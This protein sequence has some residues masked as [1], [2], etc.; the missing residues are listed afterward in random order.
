MFP[1]YRDAYKLYRANYDDEKLY[2]TKTLFKDNC[3]VFQMASELR[4]LEKGEYDKLCDDDLLDFMKEGDNELNP[5]A[6]IVSNTYSLAAKCGKEIRA[7]KIM[8]DAYNQ[9]IELLTNRYLKDK[10]KVNRTK[11]SVFKTSQKYFEECLES[12]EKLN[13]LAL[14]R[15]THVIKMIEEDR[16]TLD[17]FSEL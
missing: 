1:G 8:R 16:D 10:N 13:A 6:K 9:Y 5:I 3:T 11:L 4:K 17:K 12:I 15:N 14:Q 2:N 7:P